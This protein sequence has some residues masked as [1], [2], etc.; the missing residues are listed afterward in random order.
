MLTVVVA[1]VVDLPLGIVGV[2]ERLL[3]ED[4]IRVVVVWCECDW[5]LAPVTRASEGVHIEV[6]PVAV[7]AIHTEACNREI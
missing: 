5:V 1:V 4:R 7:A 2:H 6:G 3:A